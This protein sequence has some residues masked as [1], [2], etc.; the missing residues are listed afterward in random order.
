MGIDLYLIFPAIPFDLNFVFIAAIVFVQLNFN[1]FATASQAQG[2]LNGLIAANQ[3][4]CIIVSVI[5]VII[6]IILFKLQ[7]FSG[8]G[9]DLYLIF[10]AIPFD[11]N[12]IFVAAIVFVQL[13]LHYFSALC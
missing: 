3:L 13:K 2:Y 4:V 11:F 12:L 8:M 6:V 7:D 10:P 9:I 5:I 1:H